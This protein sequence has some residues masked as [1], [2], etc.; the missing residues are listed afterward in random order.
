MG[1]D[2]DRRTMIS[3][4]RAAVVIVLLALGMAG[5]SSPQA[6]TTSTT[7][8]PSTTTS[9]LPSATTTTA[10]PPTTSS[11]EATT[12]ST[13]V[14]SPPQNVI[15]TASDKGAL[16]DAFLAFTHDPAS[17]IAGTESGS[18]YYAY[19]PSTATYWAVSRFVPSRQPAKGRW[20]VSKTAAISASSRRKPT[21]TGSCSQ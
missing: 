11:S 1:N 20:S 10:V 6:A 14:I 15:A 3:G 5:C 4:K 13:S 19:L 8:Q 2:P 21:V 17:E 18:V 12:T 9:T 16:V 7:G